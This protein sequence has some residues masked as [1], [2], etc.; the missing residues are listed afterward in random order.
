MSERPLLTPELVEQERARRQRIA[1]ERVAE[2]VIESVEAIT[3]EA[4]LDRLVTTPDGCVFWLPVQLEGIALAQLEPYCRTLLH[5]YMITL[6][7]P[8]YYAWRLVYE[9]DIGL[10]IGTKHSLA[11][12]RLTKNC[13]AA[14]PHA[15]KMTYTLLSEL[16][17]Q[18]LASEDELT[19]TS[20]ERLPGS[21][22]IEWSGFQCRINAKGVIYAGTGH[23]D[24]FT[25]H[26]TGD[27]ERV[28]QLL[29]AHMGVKSS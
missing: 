7:D 2:R 10:A 26:G 1:T 19:V 4:L 27:T 15:L 16:M 25:S 22:L 14:S 23:G 11:I 24:H 5:D 28:Y 17:Q 3:H 20:T 21:V 13:H 29:R 8:Q 9:K 18:E 6:L 12:E